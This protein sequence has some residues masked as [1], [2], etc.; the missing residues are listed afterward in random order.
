[1]NG[2]LDIHVLHQLDRGANLGERADPV[3]VAHF[4]CNRAVYP[5]GD[6]EEV[7]RPLI[8]PA[9]GSIWERHG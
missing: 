5:R 1:M 7:R 4:F 2:I 9:Y 8:F 6:F 3:I